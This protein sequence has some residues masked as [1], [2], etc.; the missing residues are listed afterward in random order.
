MPTA[1]LTRPD[2]YVTHC[3]KGG[4]FWTA[5]AT[6]RYFETPEQAQAALDAHADDTSGYFV[7][8]YGASRWQS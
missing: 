4:L 1:N 3:T 8:E 6:T 7:A 5:D 2:F